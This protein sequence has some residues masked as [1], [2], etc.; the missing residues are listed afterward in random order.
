M[1][2][3]QTSPSPQQMM[4]N[5]GFGSKDIFFGGDRASGASGSHEQARAQAL[6]FPL[7]GIWRPNT[8]NI[9]LCR[10]SYLLSTI[11]VDSVFKIKGFP[12]H[13]VFSIM[14]MIMEAKKICSKLC[15]KSL[16]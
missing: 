3:N 6:G 8:Y 5:V 16:T 13:K 2:S 10:I 14:G 4:S 1:S 15:T 12:V 7:T 9:V 11:E